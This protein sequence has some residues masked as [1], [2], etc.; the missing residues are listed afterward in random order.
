MVQQ[1]ASVL[2]HRFIGLVLYQSEPYTNRDK[3]QPMVKHHIKPKL[4]VLEQ[5]HQLIAQRQ[6]KSY[7]AVHEPI[8]NTHTTSCATAN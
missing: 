1:S 8:D 6:P 4:N 3:Q 5:V 7:P 2:P